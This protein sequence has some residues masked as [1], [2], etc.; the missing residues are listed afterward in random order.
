MG[1][2][3]KL[4]VTGIV[5]Q[6][7]LLTFELGNEHIKL[8]VDFLQLD[9]F[10]FNFEQPFSELRI[11]GV[12]NIILT[13]FWLGREAFLTSTIA[14]LRVGASIFVKS[15]A[16]TSVDRPRPIPP[17]VIL[18]LFQDQADA[19]KYV[20]DVIDTTLLYLEVFD[21]VIEIESLVWCFFEQ[22][23]EL[24]RQFYQTVLLATSPSFV[25]SAFVSTVR[26]GDAVP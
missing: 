20:G 17:N 18:P 7:D 14:T 4:R 23:N 2:V 13:C 8:F 1:Y 24:F 6:V 19:F 11:Y 16:L 12:Q 10:L 25:L 9:L 5:L 15:G 21:C 22:T 26:L 3:C